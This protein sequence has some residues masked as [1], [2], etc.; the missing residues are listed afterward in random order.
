[1]IELKNRNDC[2]LVENG[3]FEVHRNGDIYRNTKHGKKKCTIYKTSK[4]KKYRAVSAMKDGKQKNFYVH[5]L[6]AQAFIPNPK[7]KPQINHIDGDP[8]NNSIENLEW[9]TAKENVVHAYNTGL[10]RTLETSN[11]CVSCENKTMNKDNVCSNCK[12]NIKK[13]GRKLT[14]DKEL[15]N[16]LENI[17]VSI[18]TKNEKTAVEY[19]RKAMTYKEIGQLMGVTRQR[20]EQLIKTAL[21]KS[22]NFRKKEITIRTSSKNY[23]QSSKNKLWNI[24]KSQRI[25]QEKVAEL[26]GITK[27]TYSSKENDLERFKIHEAKKLCEFFNLTL[28][29]LFG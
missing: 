14:R 28:D 15:V 19:R 23:T 11:K 12:N 8:S 25:R 6:V 5:R 20:I 29:E 22:E 3:L 7:N 10:A 2:K 26:L 1:M 16:S 18:L 13:I 27:S 21:S 17:E 9:V 24:R 4:N